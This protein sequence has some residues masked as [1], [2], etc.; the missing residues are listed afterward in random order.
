MPR[1]TLDSRARLYLPAVLVL[2]CP[3]HRPH[4]YRSIDGSSLA[5]VSGGGSHQSFVARSVVAFSVTGADRRAM[6]RK[7]VENVHRSRADAVSKGPS[8]LSA[9][10]ITSVRS[11]ASPWAL[12][13]RTQRGMPATVASEGRQIGL[14]DRFCME[15]PATKLATQRPCEAVASHRAAGGAIRS[16]EGARTHAH[17]SSR[18]AAAVFRAFRRRSSSR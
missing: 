2:I 4:R 16:I 9:P 18:G 8:A 11:S 13:C 17:G 6:V 15:L 5:G 12:S 10:T 1:A 3:A 14:R 7:C